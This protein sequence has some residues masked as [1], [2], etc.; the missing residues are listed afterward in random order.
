[1]KVGILTFHDVINAGAFL[2][3]YASITLLRKLGHAPEIIDYTT[4]L[5]RYSA[6]KHLRQMGWRALVRPRQ[7]FDTRATQKAF[8][9]CRAIHFPMSRR[10]DTNQDLGNAY[11]D[12]VLIGSDIVWDFRLPHLGHDPVYF[13]AGLNTP[14]LTAF[15][16]SCGTVRPEDS[17]PDYVREGLARFKSISVRDRNTQAMVAHAGYPEPPLVGDPTFLFS[18]EPKP[19]GKV[20]DE[21]LCYI[22]PGLSTKPFIDSIL[23]LSRR[24]R[25]PIRAVV[26]RVPWAHSNDVVC[27]PFDWWKRI[28]N[29][30]YFV[31]NTF[32]GTIFA[33]IQQA[34]FAVEMNDNIRFK[35]ER[36]VTEGG[37]SGHVFAP[38]AALE[39]ILHAETD[40][41]A[42]RAW[43]NEQAAVS[44]RFIEASLA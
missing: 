26:Y 2:Q 24:T 20:T 25:L 9:G 35:I 44:R 27:T 1:M 41:G 13:G 34:R 40:W 16:A 21:I 37:L 7:W 17:I 3:A 43:M 32:H 19:T 11:Y 5:H 36:M 18:E 10:H 22:I 30:R 4:A 42:T 28:A 38:G 39:K 33:A 8:A 12:A 6:S 15:A 23:D 29:A 14:Q 31:T